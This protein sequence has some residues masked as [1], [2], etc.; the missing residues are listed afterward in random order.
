MIDQRRPVLAVD[1]ATDPRVHDD[2]RRVMDGSY[3]VAPIA[4]ADIVIGLLHIDRAGETRSV[5]TDDRDLAWS[6]AEGF[7][8]IYEHAELRR[9]LVEQRDLV[10]AAATAALE[11]VSTVGGPIELAA[12]STLGKQLTGAALDTSV[13]AALTP[14][15][16]EV[17]DLMA[18]GCTNAA[19]GRQ[20][21]VEPAT[22]KSHMRSIL[23]KL[24]A[25]NRSQAIAM[26]L[27]SRGA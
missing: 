9:R 17:A 27:R 23:R 19:I 25:S 16:R 13:T 5:D 4:P 6:F 7:G 14:R 12:D 3:A 8:R 11:T 24:G 22:V 10:A 1:T 26:M 21:V 18:A 2:L 15:E 20:L